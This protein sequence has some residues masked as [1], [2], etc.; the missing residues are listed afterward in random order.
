[1]V[2]RNAWIG[3]VDASVRKLLSSNSSGTKNNTCDSS[4]MEE[5]FI[6]PLV[7]PAKC[8]NWLEK[9]LKCFKGLDQEVLFMGGLRLKAGPLR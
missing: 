9:L 8:L 2:L 6:I 7:G 1:M 4:L 5:G 3:T